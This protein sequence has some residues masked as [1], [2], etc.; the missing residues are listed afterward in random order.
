MARRI[1]CAML[2]LLCLAACSSPSTDAGGTAPA[3]SSRA[4]ADAALG[5]PAW[6]GWVGQT[7]HIER[8]DPG[9]PAWNQA[10]QKRLGQEAP[11]ARP[12]SP[13][14]QQ[15]VDALLRTRVTD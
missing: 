11:Q 15:A 8:D 1:A 9:S 7:L 14:W 5:S 13:Q 12:G 10:V 4:P 6:Y 3:A 2:V